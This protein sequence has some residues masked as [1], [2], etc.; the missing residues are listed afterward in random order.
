MNLKLDRGFYVS[1]LTAQDK[2]DY[3]SH[4]QDKTIYDNTLAVPYP[5]TEASFDG[6]FSHVTKETETYGHSV[7]WV[8]RNSDGRA[9]GGI[10][11]A[12]VETLKSHQAEIGYWLAKPYRGQGIATDAVRRV[13]D[14]VFSEFGMVRVTGHVFIQNVGSSR[15]LEKAGYQYEGTLRKM[16]KKGDHFLD[17]KVYAKLR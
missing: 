14:F 6:F 7:N 11:L 17:A 10:G 3:V 2:A 4:F 5:Y 8:I 16:F 12:R 9:V 13:T 1:D 15:V